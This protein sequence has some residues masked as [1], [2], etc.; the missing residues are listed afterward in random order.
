MKQ[1]TSG[2]AGR[3]AALYASLLLKVL[4]GILQ[5]SV[6]RTT[7]IPKERKERKATHTLQGACSVSRPMQLTEL[8]RRSPAVSPCPCPCAV[9][10]PASHV[11]YVCAWRGVIVCVVDKHTDVDDGRRA[12]SW[13][14][15]HA[16]RISRRVGAWVVGKRKNRSVVGC[17]KKRKKCF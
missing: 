6:P 14:A 5:N 16:R 4:G 1:W 8:H 11:V 13:A 3:L 9:W 10:T 2:P 7:H 12:S 17:L 15:G